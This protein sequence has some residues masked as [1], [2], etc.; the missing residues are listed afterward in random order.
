MFNL[1]TKPNLSKKDILQSTNNGL[2][3]SDTTYLIF[4]KKRNHFVLYLDKIKIHQLTYF[5]VNQGLIYIKTLQKVNRLTLLN[6]LC[7]CKTVIF[8]V[9]YNVSIKI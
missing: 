5:V 7:V 8:E 2:V 1:N 4:K 6:L 9:L 3:Y